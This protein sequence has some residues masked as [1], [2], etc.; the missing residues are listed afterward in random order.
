MSTGF[1]GPDNPSQQLLEKTSR[2]RFFK[3]IV[4]LWLQSEVVLLEKTLRHIQIRSALT[5]YLFPDPRA[6][7]EHLP[8][9]RQLATS[10]Q[11]LLIIPN[12]VVNILYILRREDKRA[13]AAITFLE[14]ELK[15]GNQYLLCQSCV[16]VTLVRPR[17]TR[18]D[19]DAWDLYNMLDICRGLLDSSWLGTP[20][21]RNM[22]TIL[23]GICLDNPR[24]LSYPL[25][26][27]LGTATEAGVEVKNVLRFYRKWKMVS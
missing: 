22:I 5:L 14:G 3:D 11:F 15:R 7:C 8:V 4:Q 21:H 1:E 27:V 18:P 25:Q 9:I 2:I 19:S 6:L 17:M 10:G 13:S 12:I 23:T 26:L 24:N 20:D 16:S